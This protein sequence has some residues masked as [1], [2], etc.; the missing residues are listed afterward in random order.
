MMLVHPPASSACAKWRV[1][2]ACQ[3]AYFRW[4]PN[5]HRAIHW[6][7]APKPWL[8]ALEAP[9]TPDGAPSTSHLHGWY[10]ARAYA[11][12]GYSLTSLLAG[13]APNASYCARRLWAFRRAIEDDP[14]FYTLPD[15]DMVTLVPYVALWR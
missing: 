10:L 2:C 11:Y 1:R 7:G 8:L 6:R 14:R 5:L 3:G 9:E 12:L 13:G 15:P 4:K